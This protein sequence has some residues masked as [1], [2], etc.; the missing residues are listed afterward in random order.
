MRELNNNERK[1][2]RA[3]I[4]VS[5]P[6]YIHKSDDDEKV[7]LLECYEIG[8]MFAHDL[9]SNHKIDPRFSPWGN[10]SSVIFE[11]YYTE[12]LQKLLTANLSNEINDYCQ[13][14]LSALEVFKAHFISEN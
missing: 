3:L 11:N 5:I 1:I 6:D 12:T 2:I 13:T 8:F 10:G 7:D 14:F 4:D 9:L